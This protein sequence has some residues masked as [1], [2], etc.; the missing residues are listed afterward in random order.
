[1]RKQTF[2]Y[3]FASGPQHA[4]AMKGR[5]IYNHFFFTRI[6]ARHASVITLSAIMQF[7]AF[8]S[9][10]DTLRARSE[11][12]IYLQSVKYPIQ[13]PV[14]LFFFD[15]T[16]TQL[17]DAYQQLSPKEGVP[18]MGLSRG[19]SKRLVAISGYPATAEAWYGIRGYADL[20]KL[21]FQ[22]E[23]DSPSAPMQYGEILVVDGAS[24]EVTLPL[25]PLLVHIQLRSV[26]CDYSTQPYSNGSFFNKLI[27]LTYAGAE[28][29]PLGAGDA[30]E[31]LSWLNPGYLDSMAVLR[32][33]RPEMVLQEGCGEIGPSRL[34]LNRDFYCYPGPNTC[35]V[36]E[37]R[38]GADICYYPIPLRNMK[39]GCSFRLDLTILR[40]GAPEPDMPVE[41]GTVVIESITVPWMREETQTFYL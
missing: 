24:R 37:G 19:G 1:M 9:S 32:L 27:Y 35:L 30:P 5:K 41:S 16:G 10:C 4:K 36:L 11:R 12:Q 22:L 20:C 13:Y 3:S 26:S 39:A 6:A 14:D 31:S 23:K 38:V 29:R 40:K 15:T 18:I 2:F 28:C 33:P 21:S 25:N 17:L 7:P 34:N 8:F